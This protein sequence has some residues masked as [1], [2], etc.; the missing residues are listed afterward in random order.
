[1]PGTGSLRADQARIWARFRAAASR[2]ELS[3]GCP[4]RGS[5]AAQR[6]TAEQ[7]AGVAPGL[8]HG[9]LA[10]VGQDGPDVV[11]AGSGGHGVGAGVQL[12]QGEVSWRQAARTVR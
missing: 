1:M 9:G 12:R 6:K 5:A 11:C 7:G 10:R 3:R 2:G 4:A 8:L